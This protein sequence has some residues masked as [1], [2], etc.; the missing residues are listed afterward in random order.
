MD[1]VE[2]LEAKADELEA[3]LKQQ[4]SFYLQYEDMGYTAARIRMLRETAQ[5]L[6]NAQQG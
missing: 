4:T 2:L 1:E 3:W 6:R 5:E